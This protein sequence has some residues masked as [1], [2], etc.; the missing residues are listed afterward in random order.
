MI[1]KLGKELRKLRLDL[2]IT[3]HEMATQIGVSPSLLSSTETGKKPASDAL[4]NK[5]ISTFKQ[6]QDQEAFFKELAA[7]TKSEVRI[8]FAEDN[9]Q[10]NNVAMA[11]ARNFDSLSPMQ[12]EQLMQVFNDSNTKEA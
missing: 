2:G 10:A 7:E 6:I 8:K 1:T 12:L 9:E 5:L 4:I 3:L 11:F